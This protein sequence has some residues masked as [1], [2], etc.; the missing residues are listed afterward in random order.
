[1]KKI[2]LVFLA[3]FI[4]SGCE[5]RLPPEWQPHLKYVYHIS[6]YDLAE[7][8]PSDATTYF[9]DNTYFLP[10]GKWFRTVSAK[11]S[12]FGKPS[13]VW[14]C[15]DY[16]R[17]FQVFA[18]K[19]YASEAIKDFTAPQGLAVFTITLNG[20]QKHALNLVLTN[21]AGMLLYEPQTKTIRPASATELSRII[22]L[23]D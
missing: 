2:A 8:P 10:S 15:D 5:Q 17:D 23:G 9:M 21:D 12:P 7:I 6:P 14:D 22:Y 13:R 16:A 1:M 4:L 11:Y 19:R 3:L 18:R 20:E